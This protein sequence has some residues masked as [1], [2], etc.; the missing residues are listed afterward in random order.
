[1]TP[2]EGADWGVLAAIFVMAVA[3]YAMRAAGFWLM[4]HLPPSQL[5]RR[6]LEAL[7]GSVVVATVLPIIV[8]DGLAAMLAI[9]AAGTVML[10]RRN[11]LLAVVTGMAVAALVRA[12]G[13]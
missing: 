1:M 9:A 5:L 11:D 12:A 2:N 13:W 6:M 7:P 3:T 10:V 8:R 4:G